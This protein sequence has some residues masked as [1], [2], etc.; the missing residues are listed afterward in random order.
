[1]EPWSTSNKRSVTGL[2]AAP[3]VTSCTHEKEHTGSLPLECFSQPYS[4]NSQK[5]CL[6][7]HSSTQQR[8]TAMTIPSRTYFIYINEKCH[9]LSHDPERRKCLEHRMQ[10]KIPYASPRRDSWAGETLMPPMTMA[11]AQVKL[12]A[13]TT[14][15]VQREGL[16]TKKERET[17]GNATSCSMVMGG[18]RWEIT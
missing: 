3:S 1:M 8:I 18:S 4:I 12:D 13:R 14:K 9:L 17:V 5:N 10:R 6:Y 7:H 16:S 2:S 15:V 11:H